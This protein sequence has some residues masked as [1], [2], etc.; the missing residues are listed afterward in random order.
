HSEA[1]SSRAW[2]ALFKSGKSALSKSHSGA[3]AE[4]SRRNG[5]A[6]SQTRAAKTTVKSS[7][8]E[9]PPRRSAAKAGSR[10]IDPHLALC[11]RPPTLI[12]KTPVAYVLLSLREKMEVRVVL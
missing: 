3:G 10:A 9:R 8:P 11:V 6:A 5:F 7:H 12:P 1:L 2:P 4:D